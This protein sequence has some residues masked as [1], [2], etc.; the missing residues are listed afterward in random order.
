MANSTTIGDYTQPASATCSSSVVVDLTWDQLDY[1][2]TRNAQTNDDF[3]YGVVVDSSIV[4]SGN[5]TDVQ[6]N[7][8]GSQTGTVHCCRC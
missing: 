2:K 8:A 5:V 4:A 7:F 3:G 6:I 1:D